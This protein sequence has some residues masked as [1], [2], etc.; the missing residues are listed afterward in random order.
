MTSLN[1]QTEDLKG[2]DPIEKEHVDNSTAVREMLLE[3][4]IHPENLPP[5]EDVKK[6]QRKLEGENKKMLKDVKKK[7]KN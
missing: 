4:G 3:Q 5:S 7:S 1:V 6:V 2:Q